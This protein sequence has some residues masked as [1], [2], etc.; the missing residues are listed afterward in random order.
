MSSVRMCDRCATVFSE[1][2][3]GWTTFS[4][5]TRKRD[6]NTGQ[7]VTV[8]DQLDQCPECAQVTLTPTRPELTTY[9]SD[10]RQP[11]VRPSYETQER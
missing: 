6:Q 2:A 8:T 9:E 5:T 4:G 1:R 11:T 10:P 7:M 3:E